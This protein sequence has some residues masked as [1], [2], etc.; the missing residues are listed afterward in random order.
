MLYTKEVKET[1]VELNND[2]L[3][4]HRYTLASQSDDDNDEDSHDS[5]P[6]EFLTNQAYSCEVII[7]NVSPK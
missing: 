4:T 2:I 5:M 1:K 6:P 7:T 3:V